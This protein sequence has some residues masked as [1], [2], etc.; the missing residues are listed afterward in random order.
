MKIDETDLS[1]L[2][3]LSKDSRLSLR[4]IAKQVNLSPPS[5]AER[6]RKL[7]SQGVIDKYT[8]TVNREKLGLTLDCMIEVTI[9]NGEYDKFKRFVEKHPRAVFCYRV[10]GRAC[11]F[12]KLSVTGLQE[13]EAF[14]D[15][16]AQYAVACTHII[17]SEVSLSTDMKQQ[18]DISE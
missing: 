13:I 3:V 4:E 1:I 8:I 9:K 7:E 17:F 10:A 6:V 5:V 14:I 2:D 16:V 12:V 18:F 11:F 15:E